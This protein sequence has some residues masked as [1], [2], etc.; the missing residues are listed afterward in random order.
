ML[1]VINKEQQLNLKSIND[2]TLI[3]KIICEFAKKL[4]ET[5]K[6]NVNEINCLRLI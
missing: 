1:R 2:N 5:K 6:K 4:E 3:I